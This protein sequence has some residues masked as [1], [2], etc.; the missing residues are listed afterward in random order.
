[1]KKFLLILA[2]LLVVMLVTWFTGP[3]IPRPDY[4]TKLTHAPKF[5]GRS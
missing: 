1:M 2:V 3:K 4:N 5:P